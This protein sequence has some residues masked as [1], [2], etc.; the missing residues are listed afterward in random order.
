MLIFDAFDFYFARIIL[1][2]WKAILSEYETILMHVE[3][4]LFEQRIICTL[5]ENRKCIRVSHA[6]NMDV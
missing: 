1:L 3:H 6:Y 5:K 2:K 4:Q